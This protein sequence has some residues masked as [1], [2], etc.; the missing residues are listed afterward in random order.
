MEEQIIPAIAMPFAVPL[1]SCKM[2]IT[3]DTIARGMQTHQM[4]QVI[5]AIIPQI[6][7]AMPNPPLSADIVLWLSC[8]NAGSA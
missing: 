1:Q 7:D 3:I 2:P 5:K 8:W 4:Q 6:I